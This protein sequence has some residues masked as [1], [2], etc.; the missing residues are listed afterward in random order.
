VIAGVTD[1][2]RRARRVA[3][4]ATPIP[5]LVR[6]GTF[7]AGL[8]AALVAFPD[9]VLSGRFLLPIVLAVIWPAVAPRGRG[10]S[11]VALFVVAGWVLDT[12][13]YAEPVVLWRVLALASLLY[14]AHSL[15]ALAAVLPYDALVD[16]DVPVRWF[17]RAAFVLLGS[18]VLTVAVLT[19]VGETGGGVSLVATVVGLG[20][21]VATAVLLTRLLRRP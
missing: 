9:T 2:L 17:A 3:S 10:P 7:L 16:L 18:A 14:V 20:L 6:C 13:Y 11:A 19:V 5:V 21:A 4:R 1:R 8:C 15:A 12:T